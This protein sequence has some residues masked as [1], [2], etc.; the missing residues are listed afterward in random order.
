MERP[1]FT[2]ISS[3]QLKDLN[4]GLAKE[5]E[6]LVSKF[7]LIGRKSSF[8][9]RLQALSKQ[10]V[11]Y[12]FKS[13]IETAV[14]LERIWLQL[15]SNHIETA[16]GVYKSQRKMHDNKKGAL[17]WGVTDYS[18]LLFTVLNKNLQ[19]LRLKLSWTNR[20]SFGG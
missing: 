16:Y 20:F 15:K 17:R 3:T 13:Q 11:N 4:T 19:K 1:R 9:D 8:F 6:N 18:K 12:P 14:E 2:L 10:S 5:V 7:P